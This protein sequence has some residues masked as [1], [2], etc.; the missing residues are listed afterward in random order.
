MT[1]YI[2]YGIVIWGVI[3]YLRKKSPK[4]TPEQIA[5]QEAENL[6]L[7]EESRLLEEKRQAERLERERIQKEKEEKLLNE[8][9][10]SSHRV[11]FSYS[12]VNEASAIYLVN[13][14]SNDIIESSQTSLKQ[15]YSEGWKLRDLDK[16]GKS[17]QLEDFNFVLRLSRD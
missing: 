6:R 5:A 14:Y 15:L 17:A 11:Y 10:N 12:F 2:I 13:P 1:S 8:M 7:A 3:Y 9:M 16:T 4:L